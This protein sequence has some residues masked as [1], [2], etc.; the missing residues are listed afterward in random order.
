MRKLLQCKARK[1]ILK[2]TYHFSMHKD[3]IK[4]LNL[5]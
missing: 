2:Y 4:A 5:A 3:N 1:T